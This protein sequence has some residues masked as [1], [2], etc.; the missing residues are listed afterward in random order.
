M[1]LKSGEI[2]T[3][4][5]YKVSFAIILLILFIV[6]I[7]SIVMLINKDLC[8]SDIIGPYMIGLSALLAS[9]VAMISLKTNELNHISKNNRLDLSEINSLSLN[10]I[11]IINKLGVYK[12]IVN[13]KKQVDLY[14][15]LEYKQMFLKYE[16][17][18]SNKTLMYYLSI[19]TNTNG[20][21]IL[22]KIENCLV[23]ISMYNNESLAFKKS[24]D[25]NAL[26]YLPKK[27]YVKK[28]INELMDLN[29]KLY[30]I[31]KTLNTQIDK[32]KYL[33]ENENVKYI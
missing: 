24:L 4:K 9:T 14:E 21:S 28:H 33:L 32:Q 27:E 16:E 22:E 25:G 15:L 6:I 3:K 11:I 30:E 5:F 18:F 2:F 1:L 12:K 19:Y 20:F 17:F 26:D 31:L 7:L 29:N 23:F 10:L 8:Y 13:Q